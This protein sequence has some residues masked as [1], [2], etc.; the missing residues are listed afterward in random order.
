LT[1]Y[2]SHMYDKM[3]FYVSK[4]DDT[5]LVWPALDMDYVD[6]SGL[7][8]FDNDG[9]DDLNTIPPADKEKMK[10]VDHPKTEFDTDGWIRS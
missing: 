3:R 10:Q 6:F 1:F 7:V 5:E 9:G 2:F 4:V 8:K